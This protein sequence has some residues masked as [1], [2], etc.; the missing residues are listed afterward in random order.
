MQA[1]RIEGGVPLA[2]TVEASGAKN[3][4][5]PMMAASLLGDAPVRLTRVPDLR[6][7]RSMRKLL[8]LL[9]VRVE[10]ASGGLC[11]QADTA[12]GI[13]A[14]YELVR[15]MRASVLV[16]GPLLARYGRAEVSLPGGCAIG[17]RPVDQ[18]LKG[19]RALG[20]E[21]DVREGYILARAAR[22]QGGR[23]TFDLPTVG[24]TENVLMA[25]V[26]ARGETVID[27]AASPRSRRSRL[28]C[29]RWGPGS[30]VTVLLAFA[31]RGCRR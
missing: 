2:G 8:A 5:L 23:V 19:L 11:L 1:M 18:H 4:A 9:G 24:G 17:A 22:L 13:R 28:C 25:A 10:H 16:L 7:I 6:D 21:I 30:K 14:P 31:S 26:L 20:A 15:T 27:N 3:A 29:G 12:G